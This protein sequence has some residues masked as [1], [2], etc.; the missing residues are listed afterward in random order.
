MK[1]LT[2]KRTCRVSRGSG[3][4]TFG[5]SRCGG[6]CSC[7]DVSERR[8]I[9]AAGGGRSGLLLSV[10]VKIEFGFSNRNVNPLFSYK[11]KLQPC[12]NPS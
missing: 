12:K 9:C 10:L 2:L 1:G 7:L 4:V 8:S 3:R 5:N 11:T 6:C